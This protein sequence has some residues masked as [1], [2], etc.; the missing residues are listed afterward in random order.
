MNL[1]SLPDIVGM[2]VLMAVLDWLRRKY[3]YA[4]VNLWMVG[5]TFIL[6]EAVAVA[7]LR[8]SPALSR[9]AHALALDAYVLAGITFGW[10]GSKDSLPGLSRL[11]IFIPPAVPLFALTTIYGFNFSGPRLYQ[12]IAI[13]TL[14]LGIAYVAA[15]SGGDRAFRTRLV[16]IHLLVWTPITWLAATA[17]LRMLIYWGL[18]CLYLLVAFA[19]RKRVRRG[20]IGGIL[21][22]AGFIVWALCFFLHPFVRDIAFY[23]EFNRQLWTMQ[24]FLVIIGMVLLLLEE[25]TRRL[26]GEA[27]HDPLT[28]LPNRR[29]FEDRLIQSLERSRR[30]GRISAVFVIDLDNFKL[31]NDTHGHRTGDLVLLRAGHILKS[32][33]RSSDTLARCGGDEFSVIVNDL[34]RPEDCERIAEALRAAIATVDLP[35][36]TRSPLT[37]SIGYAIFPNDVSDAAE[38]CDLADV[39][40]YKDKRKKSSAHLSRAT[41][42]VIT[43]A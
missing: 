21:I 23:D 12:A 6:V 7:V 9:V 43:T 20:G 8:G 19:F 22:V 42:A 40:M 41:A 33:I 32:K 17:Q 10:A 5:L 37:G 30:T 27:M 1:L 26:E 36:G 4:S 15:F 35:P 3:R 24:K 14:L 38:L 13:A 11:Q 31:V 29:L 34:T 2:I 28:G 39:R 25:Q 16:V 18:T